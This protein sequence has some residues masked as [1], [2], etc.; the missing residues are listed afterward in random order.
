[1][2]NIIYQVRSVMEDFRYEAWLCLF[3][4]MLAVHKSLQ[5]RNW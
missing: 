4:T 1:M 2:Y 3:L 5:H